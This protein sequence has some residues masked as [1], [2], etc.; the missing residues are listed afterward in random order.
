[1]EKPACGAREKVWTPV[2]VLVTIVRSSPTVESVEVANDCEATDDPFKEVIDP[3]APPASVPQEKVP[4]DQR[5]FS[6]EL[7]HAVR[8]AP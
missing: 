4:L 1:M 8:L 3:P 6:V 2:P 7:L 5:S